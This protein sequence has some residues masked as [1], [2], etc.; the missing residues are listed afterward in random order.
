MILDV[1]DINVDICGTYA[2]EYGRRWLHLSTTDMLYVVLLF[3]YIHPS[4]SPTAQV[5][6]ISTT[7]W[8]ELKKS[9]V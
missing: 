1:N 6:T 3:S 4:N 5:A 8:Y 7:E 2:P 9:I